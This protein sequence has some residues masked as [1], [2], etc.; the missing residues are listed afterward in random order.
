MPQVASLDSLPING[1]FPSPTPG[2]HKQPGWLGRAVSVV[3][4][5]VCKIA[6]AVVF[7]VKSLINFIIWAIATPCKYIFN[8]LTSLFTSTKTTAPEPNK[9]EDTKA[10]SPGVKPSRQYLPHAQRPF[11]RAQ[12]LPRHIEDLEYQIVTDQQKIQEKLQK[13]LY[14]AETQ[15]NHYPKA[16]QGDPNAAAYY[17]QA[18]GIALLPDKAQAVVTRTYPCDDKTTIHYEAI[19]GTQT[20]IAYAQG[21]RDRMEDAHIASRF[22]VMINNL[23]VDIDITG[24]FD[25]HGGSGWSQYAS[26]NM[27]RHLKRRIE[28]W[29]PNGLHDDGIWNALKLALV[30]L[31]IESPLIPAGQS[32]ES[33]R[34]ELDKSG[35]TANVAL[36]IN[37]DLWIVNLGDSRAILID[38]RGRVRQVSEDAEPD[39]PRYK[40]SIEKRGG[41]VLDVRG[42]PRVNGNLA[43]A[44]SLGDHS[45]NGA[46]SAR[47][48]VVKIPA[49]EST[50][51][52]LIQMCDGISEVAF[53]A[54]IARTV[55]RQLNQGNPVHVAAA[56]PLAKA[57][58]A[59]S[60]DNMSVMVT[61]LPALAPTG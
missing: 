32:A 43:V 45:L 9:T 20:G 4:D 11:N 27:V 37:G 42:V 3:V 57:Y 16:F 58:Q 51:G 33:F 40:H 50:G 21:A 46:I 29:N 14:A 5:V 38:N 31:D 17:Q 53:S 12:Y 19:P 1:T 48:K 26:Q 54:D 60:M 2:A 28:E 41:E 7:T 18:P 52:K 8:G 22:T 61:V 25:G 6:R 13:E 15:L 59:G 55:D 47:G 44:R 10:I 36:R 39:D 49:H 30:D 35:T 56:R 24:I 34:Y 23:P